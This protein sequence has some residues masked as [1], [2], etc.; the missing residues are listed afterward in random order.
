[1]AGS[2][3]A[4]GRERQ[5]VGGVAHCGCVTEESATHIRED[6]RAADPL[7]QGQSK[8][9]FKRGDLSR[10][11]WLRQAENAARGRQRA[12]VG[13]LVEGTKQ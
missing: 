12:C 5:G 2:D 7:E 11:G 8:G 13:R 3:K 10:E 1:M 9:R 4:G 6:Q